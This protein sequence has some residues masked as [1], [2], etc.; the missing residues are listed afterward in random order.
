[1]RY[2]GLYRLRTRQRWQEGNNFTYTYD[3]WKGFIIKCRDH[4]TSSLM[5]RWTESTCKKILKRICRPR[6]VL[7]IDVINF[8]KKNIKTHFYEKCLCTWN[9]LFLRYWRNYWQLTEWCGLRYV[10][11]CMFGVNNVHVTGYGVSLKI[12]KSKYKIH[13]CLSGSTL[14]SLIF[15]FLYMNILNY[16]Y[17]LQTKSVGKIKMLQRRFF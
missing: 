6:T 7:S 4:Q 3:H 12:S 13:Y 10:D 17:L 14:I 5:C 15:Q 11:L 9:Y 1:M 8:R 2:G 16:S